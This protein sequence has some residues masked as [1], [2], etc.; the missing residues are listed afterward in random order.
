MDFESASPFR[1]QQAVRDVDQY[2][3]PCYSCHP[4]P[5]DM[6]FQPGPVRYCYVGSQ[7]R[8]FG[9]SGQIARL[10]VRPKM[11]QFSTD[12]P[13]VRPPGP[14]LR[15]RQTWSDVPQRSQALPDTPKTPPRRPRGAQE[16]PKTAQKPPRGPQ[17]HLQSHPK[18][19]FWT[20]KAVEKHIIFVVI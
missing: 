15:H 2:C 6:A 9:L 3:Y 8:V 12:L 5:G 19:I 18:A 7:A 16:A 10:L 1:G 13:R 4:C 14:A 17:K 11:K 20:F